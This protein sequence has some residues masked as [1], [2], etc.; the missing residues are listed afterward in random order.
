MCVDSGKANVREDE[1]S[2]VAEI[3]GVIVKLLLC[4]CVSVLL[5]VVVCCCVALLCFCCCAVLKVFLIRCIT[6]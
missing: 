4:Y 1:G 5:C 3:V 2:Q 6:V